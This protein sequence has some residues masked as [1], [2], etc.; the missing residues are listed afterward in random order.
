MWIG[1]RKKIWKLT[2]QALALRWSE[3]SDSL[4]RRANARNGR[5]RISLRWPAQFVCR[6]AHA[7]KE[8]SGSGRN[9]LKDW[10][11]LLV[12]CLWYKHPACKLVYVSTSEQKNHKSKKAELNSNLDR[13]K[14]K[15]STAVDS[16][17]ELNSSNLIQFEPKQIVIIIIRYNDLCIR[18]GTWKFL[19]LKQSRSKGEIPAWAR[20]K[21][22]LT[23]SKF[24]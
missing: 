5:F 15:K 12:S 11:S 6:S 14:L 1:H 7:S 3:A 9:T 16:D 24:K 10:S 21:E 22:R 20:R 2:F 18:F 23:R 4:R 17:A 8:H 13:P 19:R